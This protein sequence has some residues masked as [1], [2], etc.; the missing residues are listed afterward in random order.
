MPCVVCDSDASKLKTP[1]SELLGTYKKEGDCVTYTV[2]PGL[3]A[4][5]ICVCMYCCGCPF[6]GW[7]IT[8]C[9]TSDQGDCYAGMSGSSYMQITVKDKDTM[10]VYDCSEVKKVAPEGQEMSR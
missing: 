10:L 3:C 7:N 8:A 1:P 4:T 5:D 9:K 2:H 6:Y